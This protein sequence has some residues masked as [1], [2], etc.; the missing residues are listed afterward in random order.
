MTSPIQ[1]IRIIPD[2]QE[3]CLERYR[4]SIGTTKKVIE[5]FG[6]IEQFCNTPFLAWK[7]EFHRCGGDYIDSV[8]PS[9]VSAPVMRGED[10]WGRPYIT[11]K[12]EQCGKKTG[13]FKMNP[14]DKKGVETLFQRYTKDQDVWVSGNHFARC[15]IDMHALR[16]KEFSDFAAFLQGNPIQAY[17]YNFYQTQ[18][19]LDQ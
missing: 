9:D 2:T 8:Q 11:V 12:T 5:A 13:D 1:A 17:C 3:K 7:S 14:E 10:P 4:D 15:T 19:K 6:G 18:V 16:E